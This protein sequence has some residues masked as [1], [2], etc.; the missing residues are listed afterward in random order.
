MFEEGVEALFKAFV[1]KPFSYQGKYWT[2][3]AEVP[4]RDYTLKEITL[5]PA[6]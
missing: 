4:Y 5:M 1:G 6:P 3:S 2:I